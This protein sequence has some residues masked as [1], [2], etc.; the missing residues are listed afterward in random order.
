[1]TKFVTYP[2]TIIVRPFNLT[3]HID[4]IVQIEKTGGGEVQISVDCWQGNFFHRERERKM[5]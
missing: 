4:R 2:V 5:E 3:A 1:M